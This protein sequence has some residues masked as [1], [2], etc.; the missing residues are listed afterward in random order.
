R[1]DG[2]TAFWNRS[3]REYRNGFGTTGNF[4][5]GNDYVHMFTSVKAGAKTTLRIEL[6]DDRNP[7]ATHAT[8][9]YLY[10]EYDF[11]LGDESTS[12]QLWLQGF[13]PSVGNA[14]TGWYDITYSSGHPFSTVDRINDPEPKCVTDYHLGGWWLHY[15]TL[16]SLNGEYVPPIAYGDGYGLMW[17]VDGLYVINPRRTRMMIRYADPKQEG[18][19]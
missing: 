9:F 7:K 13:W 2:S 5:A 12:Y 15:C 18:S 4:W 6:W 16:S 14:S 11:K 3:W 17:I 19:S 10:S 1:N 8:S